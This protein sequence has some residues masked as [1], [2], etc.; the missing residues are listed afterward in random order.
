MNTQAQLSRMIE[1][2]FYIKAFLPKRN[3]PVQR[4]YGT[5]HM[6]RNW[7]NELRQ[8]RHVSC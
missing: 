2:V 5:R 7:I 8:L 3:D 6:I 1:L 4:D